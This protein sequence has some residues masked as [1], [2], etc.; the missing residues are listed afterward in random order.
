MC[1]SWRR[2]LPSRFRIPR[3][4]AT[5]RCRLLVI[6][7]EDQM[8]SLRRLS[9]Q[10]GIPLLLSYC[11][12]PS[13]QASSAL[14]LA[15]IHTRGTLPDGASDILCPTSIRKGWIPPTSLTSLEGNKRECTCLA[16]LYASYITVLLVTRS[17]PFP[18]APMVSCTQPRTPDFGFA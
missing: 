15:P 12:G 1:A 11:K 18:R 10:P 5:C 4:M 3:M 14:L 17:C 16:D 8:D 9:Y 13:A 6:F 7:Y 2:F